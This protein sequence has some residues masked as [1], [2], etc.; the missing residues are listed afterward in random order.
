MHTF[1]EVALFNLAYPP[2]KQQFHDA[3]KHFYFVINV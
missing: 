1:S 2:I 3:V